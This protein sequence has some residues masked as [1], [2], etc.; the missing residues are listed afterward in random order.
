MKKIIKKQGNSLF[1]RI[2]AD[3][4]R[5]YN[6]KVGDV[7]DMSDVVKDKGDKNEKSKKTKVKVLQS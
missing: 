3:D 1:I 2:T 4:C 5:I 7:L 6:W